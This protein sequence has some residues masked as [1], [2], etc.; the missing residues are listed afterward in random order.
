MSGNLIKA[1]LIAAVVILFAAAHNASRAAVATPECLAGAFKAKTET[2]DYNINLTSGDF[3]N[4]PGTGIA[5]TQAAIGCV[6]LM[7]S[8]AV[9]T[10]NN[11]IKLRA[12]IDGGAYVAEPREVNFT[13]NFDTYRATRAFNF[14][15]RAIPAGNHTAVVQ[16]RPSFASGSGK[17]GERSTVVFYRK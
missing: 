2:I 12:V 16:A 13:A 6:L 8:S 7:F 10:E 15:F 4:V 3:M 9:E 1:A 11:Q 5:F 17:L 14:V